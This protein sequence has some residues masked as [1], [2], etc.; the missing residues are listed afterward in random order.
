MPKFAFAQ[1]RKLGNV[2]RANHVFAISSLI[3]LFLCFSH[4]IL[5]FKCD[6]III[7]SK[8]SSLFV[9]ILS[10]NYMTL[11]SRNTDTKNVQLSRYKNVKCINSRLL[12]NSQIIVH[13]NPA[14]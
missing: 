10:L 8:Q 9:Y 11:N 2:S 6:M 3:N 13:N 14:E 5:A 1:C 4:S 12:A 7:K